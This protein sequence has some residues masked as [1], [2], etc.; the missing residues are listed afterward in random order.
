MPFF[1][2]NIMPGQ[3]PSRHAAQTKHLRPRGASLRNDF[4]APAF[5]KAWFK[6]FEDLGVPWVR[7]FL[8]PATR[9]K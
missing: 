6:N 1:D 4:N 7:F 5:C 2:C 8:E 9:H 3:P